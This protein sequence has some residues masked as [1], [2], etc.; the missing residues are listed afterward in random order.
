M[1][2]EEAI[3]TQKWLHENHFLFNSTFEDVQA[4]TEIAIKAIKDR[5][6]LIKAIKKIKEEIREESKKNYTNAIFNKGL[7]RAVEI[8]DKHTEELV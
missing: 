6:K 2:N 5:A 7:Y 3:K 4:S 1:T 8:I